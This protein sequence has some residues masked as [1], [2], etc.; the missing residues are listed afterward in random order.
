MRPSA[1]N[2]PADHKCARL[3][4]HSYRFRLHITGP[5]NPTTGWVVDFGG[6]VRAAGDLIVGQTRSLLPERV[7]GLENPTAERLA[8]WIWERVS[9]TVLGG[10]NA[11]GYRLAAVEVFET[12]TTGGCC[13]P[14]SDSRS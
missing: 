10:K 6:I 7:E 4:G 8:E 13:L 1:P 11:E 12:C 14:P 3:H 5:V 9:V 2:L